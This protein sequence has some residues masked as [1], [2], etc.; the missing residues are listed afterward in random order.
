M[1]FDAR[2]NF[3]RFSDPDSIDFYLEKIRKIGF[4]DAVVDV[5]PTSGGVLFASEFFP[6]ITEWREFERPAFDYLARFIEKAHAVGLKVHA[7]MNVFVPFSQTEAC[8]D[9]DWQLISMVYMPEHG[10]VPV[11]KSKYSATVNPLSPDFR[12]QI[13][14]LI[15][16]LLKKYPDLDGLILDRVRYGGIMAD[17]SDLS[18]NGFEEY[19]GEKISSFP[20]DIY[21]WKTGTNGKFNYIRGP[22]F[23]KWIEWRAKS[24]YDFMSRARQIAKQT[25]PGISFGTYTGAWYPSYFEVG[26]NWASQQYDPS[27]DFDWATPGYKN[28]G[29][30][31]MLDLFT[32][33]NYYSSVSKKEYLKT[34]K[35]V[36]NETD[37]QAFRGIWYCVEGSCEK[38][39]EILKDNPFLGG[40]LADKFYDKPEQLA[41]SIAM[42]LQVSDGVMVFDI[43]HIIEKNLWNQIEKGF[44][45][46]EDDDFFQKE[47][48]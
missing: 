28:Y 7:S 43:S 12:E 37:S 48:H 33:G 24:I 10:I 34:N 19:V 6:R 29:Y 46:A 14:Q 11:K 21:E 4:T 30:A 36:Q 5:R 39:R 13:L 41:R 40:V 3:Q 2:A 35:L 23:N 27:E 25:N 47:T 42:D 1:W 15:T 9:P 20:T 31:E 16:E 32:V 18:R 44:A 17:F 26:V 22:W 8:I 38:I 45:M